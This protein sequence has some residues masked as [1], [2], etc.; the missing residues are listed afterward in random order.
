MLSSYMENHFDTIHFRHTLEDYHADFHL[1]ERFEIFFFISGNVNYFI[2]KKV[3]QLKYGD[4]FVINN[5]EIH[6]PSILSN[7]AYERITVH[8]DPAISQMFSTESCDLQKCF[9]DRPIGEKNKVSLNLDQTAEILGLFYRLGRLNQNPN[10]YNKMLKISCFIELL[11]FINK[12]FLRGDNL[13]EYMSI[14]G[15]L[16][17]I[18]DHIDENLDSDLSLKR[19]EETFYI[20]RAYLSRLFKKSTGSNIHE[21]II[22]KRI[23][24]AKQLIAEGYNATEA[25]LQCGFNDYSNFSRTFKK[26]V[27]MSLR[28]YKK[29]IQSW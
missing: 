4:L 14:P 22:Y 2:E 24:K 1:H 28:D 15:K 10:P 13:E 25:C 23:S 8:F 27:G 17:P 19:L 12:A 16:I 29:T 20:D 18:L 5:R 9:L 7:E 3:Y 11:V 6:K 21:Y 26:T